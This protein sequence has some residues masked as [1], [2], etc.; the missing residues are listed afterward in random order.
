MQPQSCAPLRAPPPCPAT[1]AKGPRR[2][3]WRDGRFRCRP[4]R[5]PT[6]GRRRCECVFPHPSIGLKGMTIH[7]LHPSFFCYFLHC[8]AFLRGPIHLPAKDSFTIKS[9]AG[10]R[11]HIPF[12]AADRAPRARHP[13]HQ[14]SLARDSLQHPGAAYRGRRL[15]RSLRR[16]GSGGHRGSQPR[17]EPG[18]L[19]GSVLRRRLLPSAAILL[20]WRSAPAFRLSPAASRPH[21]AAS[22]I[23]ETRCD[24]I[25]LDPP[26]SAAGEYDHTL[27]GIGQQADSLLTPGGIVVAEHSRKMTQP[28]KESYGPLQ[29]YRVLE[30][31]D[32]GLSFYQT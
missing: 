29:R 20:R 24:I 25:F 26:Y 3:T 9:D 14:R 10:D 22:P 18:L 28:L 16:L 19:C 7:A 30:Q 5:R 11:R 6:A 4:Y 2:G 12:A 8:R 27:A 15:R 23:R 17:R 21:C 31:G 32:A 13:A 1:P